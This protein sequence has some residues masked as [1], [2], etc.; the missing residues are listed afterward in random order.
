[1]DNVSIA[2]A[3]ADDNGTYGKRGKS[4]KLIYV[5]DGVFQQQAHKI[6]NEYFINVR[7][8]SAASAKPLFNKKYI[9]PS[10]VFRLTRQYRHSI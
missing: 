2:S 10:N 1:M 8:T 5:K 7:D 6:L 4:S 9:D 3:R